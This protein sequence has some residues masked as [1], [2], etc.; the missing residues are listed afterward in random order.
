MKGVYFK[1]T[2]NTLLTFVLSKPYISSYSRSSSLYSA[3][4]RCIW[5][6][7]IFVTIL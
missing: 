6:E 3:V 7:Q 4:D 1:V 5:K 2:K